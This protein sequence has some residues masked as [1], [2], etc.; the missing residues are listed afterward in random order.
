MISPIVG[1]TPY[2]TIVFSSTETIKIL[3]SQ[4]E[5]T[6]DFSARKKAFIAGSLSG[7]MA[8]FIYNPVELLKVR[9]Q[10]NRQQ[11]VRYS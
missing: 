1:V 11:F 6:Q 9:A 4:H 8:L 2:N 3:L 7:G 5:K 10:V